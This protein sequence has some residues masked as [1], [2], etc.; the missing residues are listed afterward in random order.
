MINALSAMTLAIFTR[1]IEEK[2][3]GWSREE[4]EVLLA[5][6]RADKRNTNIHAYYQM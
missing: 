3:L 5:G 1:P 6:V 2:G 4:T